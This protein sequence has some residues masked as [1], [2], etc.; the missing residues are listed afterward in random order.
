M[1]QLVTSS[2]WYQDCSKWMSRCPTRWACLI[3]CI[4]KP[5]WFPFCSKRWRAS[6]GTMPRRPIPWS[7]PRF[8]P[9]RIASC[10][11]CPRAACEPVRV[12]WLALAEWYVHVCVCTC[13]LWS[14]SVALDFLLFRSFS[15]PYF[16][17]SFPTINTVAVPS[18]K[19]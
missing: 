3:T 13:D 19:S 12:G 17:N 1:F 14:H 11:A 6:C 8:G 7:W 15:P 9:W 4:G 5:S 18:F 16:F 10:F 2:C